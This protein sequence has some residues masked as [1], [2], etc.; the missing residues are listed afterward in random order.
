MM[1]TT[2]DCYQP[3]L[4]I[5]EDDPADRDL[6]RRALADAEVRV[7]IVN[8]G[9][10][11]LGFLAERRNEAGNPGMP[12]LVIVDLNMPKVDGKSVVRSV[13]GGLDGD[14]LPIVVFSSSNNRAEVQECYEAGCTSYIIKPTDLV[15]FF[16]A[17]NKVVDYW[18]N[19]VERPSD[20][21]G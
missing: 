5:G 19:L 7:E 2:V 18:L 3:L 21:A 13:R 17:V 4:L 1:T 12:D 15:P 6:I 14:R 16:A 8:D 11:V 9:A 20:S 10:Q